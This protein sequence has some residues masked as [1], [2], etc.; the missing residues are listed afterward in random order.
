MVIEKPLNKLIIFL[1][2][3]F[4]AG[5]IPIAPGTAG[6]LVGIGLY[7]LLNG[8]SIAY[9]LLIISFLFI[10]GVY[11]S[12]EA[13]ALLK[14][15]DPSHV[16]FDEI[17]GML[18]TM[19]LIPAGIGWIVAGFFLFRFFDILKPYPIRDIEKRMNGGLG[20]MLDDVA[21]GIYANVLLQGVRLYVG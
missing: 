16:V 13:E 10:F 2:T 5:Y 15:K 12:N 21:A 17:I 7:L 11:I 14:K 1:A 9:Y 4:Y 18:V 20:I 6:S 19:I 3:G 8:L